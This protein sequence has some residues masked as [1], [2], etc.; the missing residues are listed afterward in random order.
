MLREK[1]VKKARV[2]IRQAR[3]D[4]ELEIDSDEAGRFTFQTLSAGR[5]NLQI[6]PRG[7]WPEEVKD[8]LIPRENGV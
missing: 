2:S 5:Y 7:F 3:S 4:K 1:P 6:S 8:L